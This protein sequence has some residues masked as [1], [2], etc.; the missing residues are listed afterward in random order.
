MSGSQHYS[1]E[2]LKA[3]INKITMVQSA[4]DVEI[5][6]LESD[7]LTYSTKIRKIQIEIDR[8]MEDRKSAS[9]TKSK[10]I[11]ELDGNNFYYKG[12]Q[13]TEHALVQYVIRG[14]G[15]KADD[16]IE[17]MFK[18]ADELVDQVNKL[19]DGKYPMSEG[20]RGTIVDNTLVTVF[21]KKEKLK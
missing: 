5:S 14:L 17:D 21:N 9:R 7:I 18:G 13:V 1:K 16:L 3:K 10:H 6:E 19:G 11:S 12:I 2:Q 8:L 4:L 20:L 15:V